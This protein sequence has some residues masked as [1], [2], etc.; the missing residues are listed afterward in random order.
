M[1]KLHKE[2]YTF[3]IYLSVLLVMRT[4]SDER[5]REYQNTHFMFYNFLSEIRTVYELM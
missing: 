5:C 1:G 2:K 3:F 4:V